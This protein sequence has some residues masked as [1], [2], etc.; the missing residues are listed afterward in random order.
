MEVPIVLPA[1]VAGLHDLF[2]AA[3]AGV[4][5][6]D[7]HAVKGSRDARATP[8]DVAGLRDV[9]RDP[10]RLYAVRRCDLACLA[11]GPRAIASND[12]HV[13]AF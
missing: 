5:D 10:E 13:H 2:G 12:R 11:L 9:G 7:V 3:G 4:V 8:L 6:E 1:V